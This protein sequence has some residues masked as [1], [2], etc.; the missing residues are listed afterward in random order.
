M[1]DDPGEEDCSYVIVAVAV[2]SIDGDHFDEV[3]ATVG[4]AGE[5]ANGDDARSRYS[6]VTTLPFPRK[7]HLDH[8]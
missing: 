1:C 8:S 3:V 7:H 6:R 5:D 2:C 4:S